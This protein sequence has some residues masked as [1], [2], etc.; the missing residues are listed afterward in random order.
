MTYPNRTVIWNG[1]IINDALPG[2][3]PGMITTQV[4]FDD[5]SA[6]AQAGP[7]VQRDGQWRTTAYRNALTGGLAGVIEGTEAEA[8]NMLRS[9]KAAASVNNA[10]LTVVTTRG[11]QTIL[12]AREGDLVVNHVRPGLIRWSTTIIATDPV[13]YQG[14]QQGGSV[15]NS[16]LQ[17]LYTY[18][19]QLTGGLTF[20]IGF[21]VAFTETGEVGEVGVFLEKG[22]RVTF[23]LRG[24]IL[25]PALRVTNRAGSFLLYWDLMLENGEYLE[26]DPVRKQALL[27]GQ[28]SRPPQVRQWPELVAGDNTITFRSAS[29]YAAARLTVNIRPLI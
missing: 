21:P 8:E 5:P 29:Y 20:P 17:V 16:R 15:D 28:S 6:V 25:N 7:R 27:Q 1:L 23:T 3:S 13:W 10:P 9:L 4:P 22:A 11:P 18:L 14:G 24:P 2:S 12:V 26:I 19:P